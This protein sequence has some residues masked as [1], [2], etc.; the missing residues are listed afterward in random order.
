MG[1]AKAPMAFLFFE[2]MAA[3]AMA[4]LIFRRKKK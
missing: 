4:F 1:R 2:A 3:E